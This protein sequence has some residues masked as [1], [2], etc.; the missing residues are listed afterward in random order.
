MTED[1]ARSEIFR[2]E[3]IERLVRH[4]RVEASLGLSPARRWTT[5]AAAL[6]LAAA[7]LLSLWLH[8]QP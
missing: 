1:G 4:E 6:L 8:L 5:L 2:K 3:A 7:A